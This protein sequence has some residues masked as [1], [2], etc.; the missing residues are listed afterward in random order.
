MKDGENPFAELP[1][2]GREPGAAAGAPVG[3]LTGLIEEAGERLRQHALGMCLVGAIGLAAAL[4]SSF[5][6][7]FF[8]IWIGQHLGFDPL[9]LQKWI[10]NPDSADTAYLTSYLGFRLATSVVS[11]VASV[12]ALSWFYPVTLSVA[13]GNAPTFAALSTAGRRL[14]TIIL[15][16]L[17]VRLLTGLGVM[18]CV[19]PGL[20]IQ[21]SLLLTG[22]VACD[23]ELGVADCLRFAWRLLSGHRLHYFGISLTAG[24]ILVFGSA[25]TCGLGVIP[26]FAFSMLL[27]AIAYVRLSGRTEP[28]LADPVVR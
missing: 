22:F 9:T 20:V 24:L 8:G 26:G 25:L 15:T 4:I 11:S 10:A 16:L 17:A 7:A 23:T 27:G 2:A 3:H 14:P 21:W 28:G 19:L 1:R 12:V 6:V 5:G 18:A 13:R